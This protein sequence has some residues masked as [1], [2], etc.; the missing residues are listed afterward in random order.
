VGVLKRLRTFAKNFSRRKSATEVDKLLTFLGVD[1]AS[2]KDI[3]EAT[4]F[5]C[6][7]LLS[8]SIGKLPL[9]LLQYTERQG[10]Q[11]MRRDP[12]YYIL[13]TRPNP[14]MTA[15]LFWNT[16]EYNRSYY[17]NAYVLI[18]GAGA[19]MTLW[20]LPSD[21]VQIVNDDKDLFKGGAGKIYYVYSG[22]QGVYTFN[23]EEILHFRSS[24]TFDGITGTSVRDRLESMI[25]GNIDAQKMLN[26][27]YKNGYTGKA[28]L[29]YTGDLSD[30]LVKTYVKGIEQYA[31][32]KS[33]SI[34]GE[35]ISTM[36]PIPVGS[37]LTPLN[38]KLADGQFIEIKKYSALQIAAAF[39]IKP[40]QINDYEK[41]SYASG[42]H[43]QLVFYVETLLFIL[44]QY[45]EE[46]SYKLLSPEEIAAGMYFKF[47]IDAIL[48][49]DYATKVKTLREA[50]MGTLM[51]PNEARE[52][53]DLGTVEHGDTLITQGANIFLDQV[54]AQYNA[55][56]PAAPPEEGEN[57]DAER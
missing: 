12:R 33:L 56:S 28:V 46:L 23:D 40:N 5:A 53:L 57:E 31:K 47:N 21:R 10:V 35:E 43:Q 54:G 14:Y 29:Q 7:R 18:V 20:I 52:K 4:F 45:E 38:V 16:V 36:I 13:G 24:S 8:E 22:N 34:D 25:S 27:M 11:T 17:G 2:G 51:T 6:M 32:G 44:K 49:A 19:K 3:N 55:Q 39:G 41:S 26:K 37:T 15:T 30:E 1:R 42:E 9:K 48:R 50:V